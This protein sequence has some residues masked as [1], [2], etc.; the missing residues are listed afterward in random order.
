MKQT[1]ENYLLFC[2]KLPSSLFCILT[3]LLEAT[4]FPVSFGVDFDWR[5]NEIST[6]GLTRRHPLTMKSGLFDDAKALGMDTELWLDLRPTAIHPKAAMDHLQTQ[7]GTDS[8]VD[9]IVL[10]ERV[11]QNMIEFSDLYLSAT[12]ILYHDTSNGDIFFSTGR[13]LSFPFGRFQAPPPEAA[14]VVEDPIQAIA[15]V[16]AGKWLFLGNNDEDD[17]GNEERETTRMNAVGNF[18]DIANSAS[19]IGSWCSS[20]ANGGLLLPVSGGKEKTKTEQKS[21]ADESFICGGVAV[22]CSTK[23]A[24]MKLASTLQLTRLGT[25]ASMT[26]SGIMMQ[27]SS[28]SSRILCTAAALPFDVDIWQAALLVFGAQ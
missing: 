27:S 2:R 8:F 22:Q 28:D 7:L 16:T 1:E 26:D 23:S 20:L 6:Y 17:C 5:N 4:A 13:G 21:E 10:S 14:V 3:F 12:Q 18:L 15:V 25:R 24:V 11:F 9:R 19:G